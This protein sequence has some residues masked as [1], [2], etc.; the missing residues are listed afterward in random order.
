MLIA[1]TDTS[2]SAVEWALSELIRHPR[3]M[4]KLQKELEQVVGMGRH[5]EEL[6]LENL[7]YLDSVVK[8][9]LRLHPVVPLLIH[10]SVEDCTL[11]GYHVPR[12]SRLVI[13]VL[14]IGR[15]PN[16]WK[17]DPEMFKPE[18]FREGNVD[19]R[20]HDFELIPFGSGRRG[21]PG[22]QLGLIVVQLL[23]AQLVHCFDWEL[24]DGML[25]SDLNMDD[26]FGMVVGREKHLKAIPTYRLLK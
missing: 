3:C 21:C 25:P 8:E 14:S 24:P 13:N 26:H 4:K 23:V 12:G 2:A 18:R 1:G 22:M 10:E 15:D 11:D 9:T 5:V 6:H 16:A 7:D 19:L 20:G 17:D